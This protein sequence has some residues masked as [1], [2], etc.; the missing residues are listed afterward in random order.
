MTMT[1]RPLAFFIPFSFGR[2]V[3][4]VNVTLARVLAENGHDID[5]VAGSS[6]GPYFSELNGKVR[7][8][9]LSVGNTLAGL[10]ALVRY[11]KAERPSA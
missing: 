11:L 4:R 3:E 10:P 1:S 7:I 9:D 8:I 6:A 2:G 5:V